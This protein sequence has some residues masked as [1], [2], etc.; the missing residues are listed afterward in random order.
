MAATRKPFVGG[1]WKSNGTVE[2]AKTLCAALNSGAPA[3]RNK[4]D[5]VICPIAPQLGLVSRLVR[6]SPIRAA[7]QDVSATAEGAFTG[8]ISVKQLK[9]LGISWTLIGH[10]ERRTKYGET[11]EV[12]A[13]KVE[14]CQ[15]GGMSVIFCI[16]ET[17]QERE[18][19]K[20]N[21]VNKRMLDAVISKIKDWKKVVI[22]YEPVWA[23]GTGKV[24]TPEQAQEAHEAI[25]KMIETSVSEAVAKQV[26][27][28]YGGSVTPDNCKELIAKPDID[29][30]LVGGASLKP[31]FNEIITACVPIV[32][33]KVPKFGKVEGIQ[34]AAKGVNVYAKVQQAPEKVGDDLHEVVVGDESGLVTLRVPQDR[35]DVCKVGTSLRI[36]NAHVAMVKGFIRLVVDKWAALKPAEAANE[37]KEVGTKD[38]S[39]LEYELSK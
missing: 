19:G 15:E 4:V 7:A 25:R 11:D 29:G 24:A 6:K 21:D 18:A 36:Q 26:R 8:E 5:V 14:K 39:A 12:T 16:G 35:I 38:V 22:A 17:L 1:N 13:N 20:T 31:S 2:S 34:P 10:S 27:I 9:D 32:P 33:L 3:Y 37:V 28:L 23:I 30:F